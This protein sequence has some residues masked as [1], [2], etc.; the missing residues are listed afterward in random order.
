MFRHYLGG[1]FFL[2]IICFFVNGGCKEEPLLPGDIKGSVKDAET[3]YYIKDATVRL[4]KSNDLYR[5]TT[6]GNDGFYYLYN[7]NPSEYE[8][9]ASKFGF[10]TLKETVK[11]ESAKTIICDLNIH[12]IPIPVISVTYLDFGLDLNTLSFTISKTA[13]SDLTYL[14]IPGQSWIT[15]SPSAGEI[16]NE[17]DTVNIVINREE[18]LTDTIK[19]AIS[20]IS[21]IGSFELQQTTIAIYL[22]GVYDV[23]SNKNYKAVKIGTQTWMA[24]NLDVG[25]RIDQKFNQ[26]DNDTIEKYCYIDAKINCNIYGGLYQWDELMQYKSSD[27]GKVGTT[28][29]ICPTGYHIPTENEWRILLNYLGN[30]AGG[31]L[32]ETGT[33]YWLPPNSDAT[34]ESGFTALPG[35][36]SAQGELFYPFNHINERGLFMCSTLG[37]PDNVPY[38]LYIWYN[39]NYGLTYNTG[40]KSFGNSVRCLKD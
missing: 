2:I 8:V 21:Y 23:R 27:T 17:P 19:G 14:I 34:N 12:E 24:V 40:G 10:D 28:R 20:I 37:G 13:S 31:K 39:N 1:T 25:K 4:I 38:F 15:A 26:T 33:E 35:G 18:L 9:Y 36:N 7:I 11:V 30:N 29:G 3:G 32:K 5:S 16:G 6:T 22:N